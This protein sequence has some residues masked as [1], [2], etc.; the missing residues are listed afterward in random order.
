MKWWLVGGGVALASLTTLYLVQRSQT[1]EPVEELP[2]NSDEDFTQQ[3]QEE[4]FLERQKAN[5]SYWNRWKAKNITTMSD[6][7]WDYQMERYQMYEDGELPTY[8]WNNPVMPPSIF[9]GV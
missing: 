2:D 3:V 4:S 1:Q 5:E 9:Y 8:R 7:M 6:K